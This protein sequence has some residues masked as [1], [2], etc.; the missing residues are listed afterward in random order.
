[1]F[2][3][4]RP[5]SPHTAARRV[6]GRHVVG[7]QV[8][9]LALMVPLLLSGCVGNSNVEL[10]E[11]TAGKVT[12]IDSQ[13]G[14][15]LLKSGEHVLL[16]DTRTVPEYIRGHLV[17]AQSVD[18]A[19]ESDWEFRVAEFDRDRP[20]V[21]YCRDV[22]CSREAADKLVAAGLTKVFDLGS[23]DDW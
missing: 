23:P 6:A 13:K 14:K 20:T 9:V 17:G 15:A 3:S 8:V 21:V 22:D 5:A 7:Q 4:R 11:A 18:M 19:N 16:I 2:T 1:M 12:T 10:P